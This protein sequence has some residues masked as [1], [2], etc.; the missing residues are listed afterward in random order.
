MDNSKKAYIEQLENNRNRQ[1]M[2]K[3]ELLLLPKGHINTLYRNGKGYYYLT[4]RNGNKIN[5][6]Y[7]G[8][9][10]K[11]DLR[12]IMEKLKKR[13]DIKKEIKNLKEE[14]KELKKKI[15]RRRK[16]VS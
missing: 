3:N 7:L 15:G 1:E 2:L 8:P 5:N 16:N 10:G 12:E 9:A 13:E 11:A 4:Y 6:D 14:E